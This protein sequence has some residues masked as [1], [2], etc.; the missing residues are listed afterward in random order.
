M[1]DRAA[2]AETRR[3]ALDARRITTMAKMFYTLEEVCQKLGKNEDEVKEMVRTGQIQEFRDR[4]KLMFKVE[5]V[6]L[7]AGGE[8][9]TSEVHLELE[10]TSGG[11]G[12]AL[13]D[14]SG[15]GI[16]LVDSREGT[17]VSV[18][19][20]DH[21]GEEA[22]RTSSFDAME[23]WRV[24]AYLDGGG[25]LFVSGSEI[26]WDLDYRGNGVSF[27]NDY[28]KARSYW[29]DFSRDSLYKALDYLNSAVEKEPDWAPLYSGLAQ[30]WI[31]I[32]NFGY[33]SSSVASP[34][35]YEYLNKALELDPD[36]SEYHYVSAMNAHLME[37]N[38]EKSEREFEQ[39]K[40]P[41]YTGSG[42][43]GYSYKT[44]L[45]GCQTWYR[46][47]KA[48]KKLM[49]PGPAHLE[50]PFH[51]FHN[52]VLQWNDHWLKGMETGIMDEPPVKIWVMGANRWRYED[53]WPPPERKNCSCTIEGSNWSWA[54]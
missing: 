6:D 50:R 14:E 16:G 29:G 19:D 24:Q 49:F 26:G 38:W 25:H 32:V 21:G 53:D 46:E 33:A 2:L 5:Q 9:D 18:F 44:H 3:A 54:A 13:K 31:G 27:Y 43:Y 37:W 11:S 28:L 36:F 41:T 39:I 22:E 15:S 47:I 34:K 4:D 10:D 48:P 51:S 42:W 8:E 7:L 17:G 45:Q 52:E 35:I 23:Q 20:T 40:V 1:G 30:V 12:V